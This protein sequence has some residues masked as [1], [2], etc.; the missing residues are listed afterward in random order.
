MT[1]GDSGPELRFHR[2]IPDTETKPYP[3]NAAVPR[4]FERHSYIS[5][6]RSDWLAGAEGFEPPHSGVLSL[7]I[8]VPCDSRGRCRHILERLALS[9]E[10]KPAR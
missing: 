2:Q 10:L 9:F 5:R 3:Q 8:N 1:L 6:W 4:R 7:R